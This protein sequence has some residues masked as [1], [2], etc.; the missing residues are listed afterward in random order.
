MLNKKEKRDCKHEWH[1]NI[2]LEGMLLL[3]TEEFFSKENTLSNA[4][5]DGWISNIFLGVG[6]QLCRSDALC[7]HHSKISNCW[8]VSAAHVRYA[9][10][11]DLSPSSC[12]V[13]KKD[14]VFSAWSIVCRGIW[15]HGINFLWRKWVAASDYLHRLF[16]TWRWSQLTFKVIQPWLNTAFTTCDPWEGSPWALPDNFWGNSSYIWNEL[17]TQSDL[18]PL[19]SFCVQHLLKWETSGDPT[20]RPLVSS[21]QL[22]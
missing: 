7:S 4:A 16:Q 6:D 1:L 8:S 22:H 5:D 12:C 3:W 20:K 21:G 14:M 19:N 11:S 15:L 17:S 9:G 13:F 2:V 18:N 10:S